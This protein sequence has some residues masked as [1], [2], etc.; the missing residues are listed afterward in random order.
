MDLRNY[1]LAKRRILKI[2]LQK[3]FLVL[4]VPIV[5]VRKSSRLINIGFFSQG[6]NPYSWEG[7]SKV[8][9]EAS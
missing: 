5:I 7:G 4:F 6:D 1:N 9:N 2:T 3:G 8:H